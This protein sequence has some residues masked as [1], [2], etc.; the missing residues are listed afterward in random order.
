M[1]QQITDCLALHSHAMSWTNHW[2]RNAKQ[3]GFGWMHTYHL[4]HL[5]NHET[6][7]FKPWQIE[8]NDALPKAPNHLL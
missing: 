1:I 4:N 8:V 7:G 5:P 6:A 2:G 3:K